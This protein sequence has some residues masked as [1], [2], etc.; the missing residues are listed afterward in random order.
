LAD[1]SWKAFERRIAAVFGTKRNG[2]VTGDGTA[3]KGTPDLESEFFSVE[4]K[5]LSRPSWGQLESA[6]AQ[7]VRNA[8]DGLEP[9]AV[10]K[11][12]GALDKDAL[13]VC[14]LETFIDWRLG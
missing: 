11:K 8:T 7:S 4:T 9:V 13:V 14:S 1:K 12:K 6:V 3:G 10:I 5:L 2:C